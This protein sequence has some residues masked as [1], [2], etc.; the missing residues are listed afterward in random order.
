MTSRHTH[1]VVALMTAALVVVVASAAAAYSTS[2][3]WE[4]GPVVGSVA[5]FAVA[6]GGA[7]WGA[8]R[9]PFVAVLVAIPLAIADL[10]LLLEIS[11]S[12]WGG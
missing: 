4:G 8:T 10:V 3:F 11:L 9:R 1:A 7:V 6:S 2:G 12:R 5:A